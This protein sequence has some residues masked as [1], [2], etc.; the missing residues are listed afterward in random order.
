MDTDGTCEGCAEVDGELLGSILTD[1]RDEGACEVLGLGCYISVFL[2]ML[3][4][5]YYFSRFSMVYT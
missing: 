5:C 4:S 2:T 3:V 1:G